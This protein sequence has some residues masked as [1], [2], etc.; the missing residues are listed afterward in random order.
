MPGLTKLFTPIKIG[1]MEVKNR[2]VMSPMTT[3]FA[4]MREEITPLMLAY[5]TA[6]AK[7]GVGMITVEVCTVD[8]P[9]NYQFKSLALWDDKF[10]AKHRELTAAIHAH[11]AKVGPQISHPGPES[12]API[13]FKMPAVGPSVIKSVMTEETCKELTKEEIAEIVEK[14]G[15][16]ARRAREAGYDG[17]ELHAAHSYMLVGSFLSPL[18]NKRTDE[19][20]GS[21]ENRARFAIEVIK[22]MKAKA[23]AD[24]PLIMRISGDEMVPGGRTLEETLRLAPMLVA[25]GVD[26]FHVSGGV[27]DKLCTVIQAGPEY[28]LG[29]NVPAATALKKAVNVPIMVVGR[30]KYPLQAEA[31]LQKGQADLVVMARALLADPNLPNKARAG[32]LD[33]IRHCISCL[34]CFDSQAA[35]EGLNCAVN[36]QLGFET[37]YTLE[38]APKP[39]KVMIIGG[40]P[41]GMEAARVAALRGHKVTLYEKQSRLGGSLIFASTVHPDN[42]DFLRYLKG[43]MAM[44]PVS[45]KLGQEATAETVAAEKPDV[46]IVALGPE[47]VA[48]K[49]PGDHHRHVMSGPDFKQILSGNLKGPGT[50]KLP[51][52]QRWG[53]AIG[54]PV[55]TS[56]TPEQVRKLTHIWMPIGKQVVVIG[57]DLA[58]CELAQ[59][60]AERGRKVTLLDSGEQ[61]APEVG[62]KRRDNVQTLL[63]RAGVTVL[64]RVTCKEITKKGV[65]IVSAEG[66]EQLIE[67]KTV[68]LAGEP[69]PNP[70]LYEAL[71]GK[72]PEVYAIGDCAKIG[73]IRKA[74]ATA[75]AVAAK[76]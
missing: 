40:G 37:E 9:H 57:A 11:G 13:L 19:Y 33:E 36:G 69:H 28:P 8:R 10:I 14:Y 64:T 67:A 24:F 60:V 54:R 20:G 32:K 53:L 3:L 42:E 21:P 22:S 49:I 41:A 27:I 31:I 30:I 4:T 48:P 16:A 26:A 46:V 44:M 58:G 25:A 47:L 1:Q 35:L 12:R 72:A 65:I 7:G 62:I 66:K 74:T 59:F 63:Q 15:D 75:M 18:R 39:K 51:S 50:K 61:I 56:L 5:Y 73:L 38:P 76:I 68:I 43:Q 34:N 23:G 55:I 17:M 70:A 71:Q 45:V 2:I 6:R 52:W 29:L